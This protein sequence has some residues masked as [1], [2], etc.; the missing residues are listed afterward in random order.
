MLIYRFIHWYKFVLADYPYICRVKKRLHLILF[1]SLILTGYG[2]QISRFH[3]AAKQYSN[4]HTYTKGLTK[5]VVALVNP[6]SIEV[7]KLCFLK[8]RILLKYIIPS[9]D[10]VSVTASSSSET[11]AKAYI[12]PDYYSPL[13]LFSGKRGPPPVA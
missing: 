7:K 8:R 2:F 1:F 3:A 6:G 4:S 10:V 12:I 5:R 11:L 13:A 9:F